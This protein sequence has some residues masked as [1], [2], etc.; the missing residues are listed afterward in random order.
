VVY[1]LWLPGVGG[2]VFGMWK[3]ASVAVRWVELASLLI[4]VTAVWMSVVVLM[5]DV[6]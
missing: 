6:C 2:K 3:T 4:R 5:S 1:G